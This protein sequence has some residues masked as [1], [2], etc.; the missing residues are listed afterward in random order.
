MS[1]GEDFFPFHCVVMIK[2][3][4]EH[5]F[6][7]SWLPTGT[8]QNTHLG[9]NITFHTSPFRLFFWTKATIYN[10][11]VSSKL[12][13]DSC[14]HCDQDPPRNTR[15]HTAPFPF[16]ENNEISM[17]EGGK[18]AFKSQ[19]ENRSCFLSSSFLIAHD[20]NFWNKAKGSLHGS[21]CLCVREWR[22]QRKGL[23]DTER[24]W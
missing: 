12:V 20:S 4:K 23:C 22:R 9:R 6:K 17:K 8:N 3:K 21:D 11:S 5:H 24:G 10:F 19:L 14:M 2:L 15:T 7:K 18:K 1:K 13:Y 16:H